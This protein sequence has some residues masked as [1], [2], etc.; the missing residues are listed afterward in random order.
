MSETFDAGWL[1]MRELFDAR[2][3][4]AALA[5]TLIATLPARPKLLDL[6]AGTGSLFRWLAPRIYRAQAWTLFDADRY[7]IEEA[8]ETIGFWAEALGLRVTMPGRATWKIQG[9]LCRSAKEARR[10]VGPEEAFAHIGLINRHT[11]LEA[12]LTLTAPDGLE[13]AP[14]GSAM[15]LTTGQLRPMPLTRD[16][17]RWTLRYPLCPARTLL[18]IHWPLLETANRT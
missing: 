3:R 4:N 7:L 1:A 9:G 15:D 12:E 10:S 11:S 18:R 2:A 16:G 5:E 17:Q 14:F 8:F 13:L 6:G